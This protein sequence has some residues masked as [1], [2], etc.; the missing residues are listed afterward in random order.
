[1]KPHEKC[2][3]AGLSGLKELYEISKMPQSTLVKWAKTRPFVFE[4]IL[5]KSA[6][7]KIKTLT[8]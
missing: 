6:R 4:A 8:K 5:E 7:E 2:K 1:M 3:T